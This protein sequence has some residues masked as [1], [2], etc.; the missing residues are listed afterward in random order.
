LQGIS[1]RTDIAMKS[2][3]FILHSRGS[4]FSQQF[5]GRFVDALWMTPHAKLQTAERKLSRASDAI[6]D[7]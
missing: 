6:R 5:Y 7:V 3:D 4:F 1:T 2:F